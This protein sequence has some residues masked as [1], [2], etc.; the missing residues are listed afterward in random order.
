MSTILVI[1]A[2]MVV[3]AVVAMIA[4]HYGF[5]APRIKQ[6]KNPADYGM[7]F[8]TIDI[9][10]ANDHQ[11]H[12]WLMPAPKSPTT[13]VLMHGWGGNAEMT[14]TMAKPFYEA[15]LE[16]L[17][18]DARNHGLSPDDSFSSLPKFAEDTSA[19]VDWLRALR[20]ERTHKVV[21]VGHSIG[22]AAVLLAASKRDDIAAVVSVSAFAHPDALMR[23]E[24]A[25]L[26]LPEFLVKMVLGYV[27]WKIGHSF[28]DIAPMNTICHITCPVLLSHG[29]VDQVIPYSDL[30]RIAENCGGDHVTTMAIEGAD[31]YTVE[32]IEAHGRDILR[33]LEC[34]G[35]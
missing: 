13:V 30:E 25:R 17:V 18:Y 15:G 2:I 8:E 32:K 14:L 35:I 22:A 3:L 24:V 1:V 9:A 5:K 27:Q 26:K 28:D 21:L 10:T 34:H 12:G 11:L 7:E 29:D 4:I 31:H 23:G 20:S 16:V 19:A 33:F 6:E